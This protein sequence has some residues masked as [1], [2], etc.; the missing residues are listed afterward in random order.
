MWRDSSE[1]RAEWRCVVDM[2]D[3]MMW[4]NDPIF[5]VKMWNKVWNL[6]RV[7]SGRAVTRVICK[8]VG[9]SGVLRG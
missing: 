5:G 9:K 2:Q 1:V 6:E 3:Y 7:C 8:H 4:V